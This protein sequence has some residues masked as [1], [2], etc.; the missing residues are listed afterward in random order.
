LCF[1]IIRYSQHP[2][3]GEVKWEVKRRHHT[4]VKGSEV[5]GLLAAVGAH[6]AQAG[7]QCDDL[8][9]VSLACLTAKIHING[10]EWEEGVACR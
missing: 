7:I 6:C 9:D 5:P 3:V 4:R 10:Q 1:Y 8:A 2:C